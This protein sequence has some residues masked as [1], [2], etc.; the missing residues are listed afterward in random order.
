MRT[1]LNKDI[2][3]LCLQFAKVHKLIKSHRVKTNKTQNIYMFLLNTHQTKGLA[4]RFYH[5]DFETK[6]SHDRFAIEAEIQKI[7]R[8][9]DALAQTVSTITKVSRTRL[10]LM[11][12]FH[13]LHSGAAH[14]FF[15]TP[16][17]RVLRVKMTQAGRYDLLEAAMMDNLHLLAPQDNDAVSPTV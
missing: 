13:K 2:Q 4:T 5:P 12:T 11:L 1:Q 17:K 7:H 3:A 10:Q 15:D 14:V 9:F 6:S 8:L 16:S